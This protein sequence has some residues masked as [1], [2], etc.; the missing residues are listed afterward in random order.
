MYY[1]LLL[2][3]KQIQLIKELAVLHIHNSSNSHMSNFCFVLKI[4]N[5][6]LLNFFYYKRF[7]CLLKK[8][9]EIDTHSKRK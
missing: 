2:I 6:N 9:K 7:K 5:K 8:I 3:L 1:I 4:W